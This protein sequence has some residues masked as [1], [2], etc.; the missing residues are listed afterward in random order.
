MQEETEAFAEHIEELAEVPRHVVLRYSNVH[1]VSMHDCEVHLARFHQQIDMEGVYV[2]M[3]WLAV[4]EERISERCQHAIR[5][6][7]YI[8]NELPV[9][10]QKLKLCMVV[11]HMVRSMREF[12][13]RHARH[14][15][16]VSKT[17]FAAD[18][19]KPSFTLECV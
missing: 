15:A 12:I 17:S 10:L 11:D 4:D 6:T 16:I 8:D 18:E 5:M 19:L 3:A 2:H 1:E 13:W 7:V 9:E 14:D